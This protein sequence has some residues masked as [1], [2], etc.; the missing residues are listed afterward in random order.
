MRCCHIARAPDEMRRTAPAARTKAGSKC[1][2]TSSATSTASSIGSGGGAGTK[3]SGWSSFMVLY[4]GTVLMMSS[5]SSFGSLRAFC[6]SRSCQKPIC[7]AICASGFAA[8]ETVPVNRRA[9]CRNFITKLDLEA[10]LTTVPPPPATIR[11]PPAVMTLPSVPPA[12]GSIRM[13]LGTAVVRAGLIIMPAPSA[14]AGAAS[15]MKCATSKRGANWQF[16][17]AYCDTAWMPTPTGPL[18]LFCS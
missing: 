6:N 9:F 15:I 10:M 4:G 12:A 11:P 16:P 17:A 5:A 8:P 13:V 18:A 3:G 2:P 1:L 14:A 7:K